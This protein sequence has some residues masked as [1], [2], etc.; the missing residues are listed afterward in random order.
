MSETSWQRRIPFQVDVAGVIQIMGKSLYSRGDAPLREIIQ[1]AHDAVM[2][3]R[4]RDVSYHGRI[5]IRLDPQHR[6]LSISD[7]GV[8][9]SPEEAERYL[10]TLGLGITGLLRGRTARDEEGTQEG[11]GE[12]LIGQFGIGLFSAFMLADRL[13]VESRRIDHAVGVRWSAGEGTEIDLE[14]FE[15]AN[16]GTTVTLHLKSFYARLADDPRHIEEAVKDYADFLPVP[17]F[18]NDAPTR[19]NVINVAWFDPTPDR[20]A[21]E[22]AL[23]EYFHESPLDVLPINIER[24]VNIKGALYVTPQRTPGFT[25]EATVTTTI[26]RMVISRQTRGLLPHWASFFRGVLELS[27]C[28][29]TASREDLVRDAMFDQVS[30]TLNELLYAHLEKLVASD[31]AT[32]EAVLSWHRYSFAGAALADERL[33]ALLT[34]CYRFNTSQGMLTFD[35]IRERSAPDPSYDSDVEKVFWYNTDRRQERW[36]NSLFLDSDAMC[37]HTTRSFEE[38]LLAAMAGDLSADGTNVELRVAS[39]SAAGFSASVLG[40]RDTEDAPPEWQEYLGATEARIMTATFR[41]E[42]PVMAFLNEKHELQRTYDDLRK[43]G[44][45]PAGFQRL[46]D[47][48]FA[49]AQSARHEVLLNRAHR[50]VGRVLSQRTGTPLAS[51]L[52]LLVANALTAAGASVPRGAQQQQLDDL[53][54]IADALWG[55]KT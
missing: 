1:N 17:I 7:D 28:A 3:R 11:D 4:Q 46:I 43:D 19:T 9:L 27:D 29:P 38:A 54:W 48:H 30:Q 15:R 18:I 26:R 8:G 10:G 33:R 55:R 37:V 2:R 39:P 6:L 45:V 50:L 41:P 20:E 51:V 16:S 32:L 23:Q 22:L 25:D 24:P 31:R 42:L 21:I 34:G 44:T 40:I 53:D 14:S 49:Q 35:E 52:R 13:V 47:A 36:V 12:G 5:D